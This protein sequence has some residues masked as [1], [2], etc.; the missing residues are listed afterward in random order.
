MRQR[1]L[2]SVSAFFSFLFKYGRCA[3]PRVFDSRQHEEGATTE[4]MRR[5]SPFKIQTAH[6]CRTTS[7]RRAQNPNVTAE[8]IPTTMISAEIF[9][10]II[11]SMCDVI[12][13]TS[14]R[15]LMIKAWNGH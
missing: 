2:R 5:M 6:H 9:C 3:P 8:S 12:Y 10:L 13:P 11:L 14:M 7:L 15:Y 4:A 1:L